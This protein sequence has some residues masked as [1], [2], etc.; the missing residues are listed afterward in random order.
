MSEAKAELERRPNLERVIFVLFSE[1]A[2]QIYRETF[3]EV[4]G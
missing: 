4:F 3:R 1:G 2:L